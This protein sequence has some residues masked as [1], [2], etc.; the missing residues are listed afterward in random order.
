MKFIRMVLVNCKKYFKDYK[1]IIFMFIIPILCVSMVN[2]I[3]GNGSNGLDIKVAVVNMDKGKLGDKIIN[4]LK[5]N[6]VYYGNKEKALNEL[7]NY[8]FIAVYEIPEDFSEKVGN[9]EKP[10]INSYKLE[11][12][13]NTQIFEAQIEEKI[14]QLLKVE[15]LKNNNIISSEKELDKNIIKVHYNKRLGLMSSEGF[16]PI[17]LI[18][19]FLVTFSSN[20]SM[21][22]LKLRKEKILER[23]LS[24]NN[25]GYTV[26]G[27]I[28]VSMLITQI[29]MYS[30]S[31]IVMDI[32]FKYHFQN[33][34]I[35]ILNVALM[36]MVSIS[37]GVMVG[38]IC[39]D[40]GV[41]SIIITLISMVMFFLYIISMIGET[42]SSVPRIVMTLSKFTPFYWALGSIDKSVL[43]PNVFVMIL[44]ALAFFSAGSIKYSNFAKNE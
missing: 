23:F 5:V 20:I 33:F 16:M 1:N 27:S 36:S 14:D 11:K 6:S 19:F 8:N 25:K 41:A 15:I 31:F 40:T 29:T 32:V 39:K 44:I 43:F 22:L 21:D 37:L 12:G 34:G 2:L 28:Y 7:K 18:M 42:S 13:N 38:R 26:M 30:M 9:S 4:D 17:V 35:L 24:T 3:T 10:V